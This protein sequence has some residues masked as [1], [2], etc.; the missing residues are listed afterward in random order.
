M[1]SPSVP[2]SSA[3]LCSS[4]NSRMSPRPACPLRTARV[5]ER[6]P[7]IWWLMRV[8]CSRRMLLPS[9]ERADRASTRSRSWVDWSSRIRV[10]V[11]RSASARAWVWAD[12]PVAE[13]SSSMDSMRVVMSSVLSAKPPTTVP[14]SV[15]SE[16]MLAPWPPK[17]RAPSSRRVAISRSAERG[18]HIG[19]GGH[20]V[21]EVG[22][23]LGALDHRAVLQEGR[24]GG[25]GQRSQLDELLPEGAGAPDPG[26][27]LGGD[28][29][30]T[31]EGQLQGGLGPGAVDVDVG[32]VADAHVGHEDRR[33]RGQ[34]GHVL[35]GRR[36]VL[37]V[38]VTAADER[39]ATEED[40]HHDRDGHRSEAGPAA[41]R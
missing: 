23:D 32:D 11:A 9:R 31:V 40:A 27:D 18:E 20:H 19:A 39:A 22:H 21:L 35:E 5:T 10:V 38:A 1:N 33:T 36:G 2:S 17:P 41:Q 7:S 16:R 15:R 3:V 30:R 24:I 12:G 28:A 37:K 29:R 26:L 14:K 4:V 34:V 8:K 13:A 6:R 25:V